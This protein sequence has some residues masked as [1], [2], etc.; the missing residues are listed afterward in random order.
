M[1]LTHVIY[2]KIGAEDFPNVECSFENETST[3]ELN[4]LIENQQQAHL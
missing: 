1:S 4:E 3:G 2:R